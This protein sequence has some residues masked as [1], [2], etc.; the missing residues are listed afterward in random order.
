MKLTAVDVVP[1]VCDAVGVTVVAPVSVVD[2]GVVVDFLGHPKACITARLASVRGVSSPSTVLTTS[3]SSAVSAVDSTCTSAVVETALSFLLVKAAGGEPNKV[4]SM[5]VV[6]VLEE[7]LSAVGAPKVIVVGVPEEVAVVGAPKE[8][9]VGVAKELAGV[10]APNE[11][12]VGIPKELTGVGAPEYLA[13]VA[14]RPGVE[15]SS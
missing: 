3:N 13:G 1:V 14:I 10:G 4:L 12:A 8:A 15:F 9:V 6:G 2:E 7:L 5:S 11:A